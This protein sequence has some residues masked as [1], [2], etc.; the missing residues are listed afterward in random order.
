LAALTCWYIW[1]ERNKAIFEERSPSVSAVVYK[2]LGSHTWLLQ[3][4]KPTP[5][6]VCTITYQEGYSIT[7]FDG[8]AILGG[9]HFGAGDIIKLPRSTVYKWYINCGER[10]NTK[11][12]LMGV[13]DTLTLAIMWSIQ[14]IQIL[15]DSKV[16]IDWLNLKSNLQVIDIEGWKHK[17]RDL[18]TFFHGINFHRFTRTSIRRQTYYLKDLSWNRKVDYLFTNGQEGLEDHLLI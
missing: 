17:N 5:I 6:R 15:G 10:T 3:S 8:V 12:E 2:I 13:W 9:K 11:A 18:T 7:C 16:I 1:L 4:L 14:K